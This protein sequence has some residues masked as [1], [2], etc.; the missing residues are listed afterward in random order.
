MNARIALA[1]LSLISATAPAFAEDAAEKT[2]FVTLSGS[3]ALVSDYRFRGLSLS[4]KDWAVQAS[5][6]AD[7]KAGFYV[8]TW[9]SS[10]DTVFGTNGG[11]G[12][13]EIDLY[14]GWTGTVAGFKPDVG[15]YSY[16]YPGAKGLDY[17]EIY[18]TIN[19]DI[20]PVATSFGV[21]YAPDQDNLVEDNTYVWAQAGMG[22]GKTP[23]SI[24]AKIGYEDGAFT[25]GDG[26]WD[27]LLGVAAKWQAVTL[28][29]QYVDTDRNDI[30]NAHDRKIGD[31]GVVFSITGAF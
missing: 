6:R 24:M 29:V 27:W 8:A 19:K 18:G 4:D 22:V 30:R 3:A 15:L 23:L 21:N 5:L 13:T 11:T 1:A 2:P 17:F 9:A 20:G 26:K 7:T 10:I 31:A 25:A 14:G 12:E 16:L 28:A